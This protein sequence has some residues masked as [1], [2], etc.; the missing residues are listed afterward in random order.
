MKKHDIYMEHRLQDMENAIGTLKRS[1]SAI[2][3]AVPEKLHND[4]SSSI[5][6]TQVELLRIALK[7]SGGKDD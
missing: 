1:L 5:K 6:N 7:K 2:K 3:S 4:I